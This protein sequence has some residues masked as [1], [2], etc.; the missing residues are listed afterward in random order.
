MYLSLINV[1]Q[2]WGFLTASWGLTPFTASKMQNGPMSG[3][4]GKMGTVSLLVIEMS[5]D[6]IQSQ[7]RVDPKASVS[8]NKFYLA[9]FAQW[10]KEY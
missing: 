3:R 10:G 5:S 2:G 9:T 7:P 1:F 8:L 6:L 4:A